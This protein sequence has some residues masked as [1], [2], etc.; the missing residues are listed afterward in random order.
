M[1]RRNVDE[2][3]VVKA[4]WSSRCAREIERAPAPWPSRGR[5]DAARSSVSGLA[6]TGRH[7]IARS[8][9]SAVRLRLLDL[10]RLVHVR[11][12]SEHCGRDWPISKTPWRGALP[13]IERERFGNG[14]TR[15]SA[16]FVERV[17]NVNAGRAEAIETVV[18]RHTFAC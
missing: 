10:D 8:I 18:A 6:L 16:D 7:P 15:E 9:G 3:G 11:F 17:E 5:L 2:A 14:A 1:R 12:C 13:A 4:N